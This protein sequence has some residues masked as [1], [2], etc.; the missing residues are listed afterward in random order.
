MSAPAVID[1][2]YLNI[3]NNEGYEM[4]KASVRSERTPMI[5]DKLTNRH[6]QKSTI[7]ILLKQSDMPFTSKGIIPDI[8]FTPNAIP[9]RMT[10]GMLLECLIGKVGALT[11]V[12]MDG[13]SFEEIDVEH[14]KD[15]LEKTGHDRDG[16]ETLYNG[17][18]GEKI[19][20]KIFVCPCFYQ[21]LKHLVF[22]KAH[23]RSTGPRTILTRQPPEGRS[24]DGGLRLGEMERDCLIAHG[25]AYFLKE[26]F[27]DSSDAYVTYVCDICGLFAQHMIHTD[28]TGTLQDLY[29]CQACNNKTK[30]SKIMI[31]YAFKLLLQELMSMCIAPRIRVNKLLN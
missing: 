6:G 16:L 15:E 3:Y 21:R 19:R 23:Q 17:M 28:K 10:I 13:T 14:I 30:I 24:R 27:L 29:Y 7:G 20:S 2:I 1:R 31:P 18:T 26:K 12:E 22:D 9:S 11:G 4:R 5:G 25:L 8:I